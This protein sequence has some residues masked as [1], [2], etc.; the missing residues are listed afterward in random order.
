MHHRN[1][2]DDKTSIG[3]Y[4][5]IE[6]A[7]I[8]QARHML[9]WL[10]M[11]VVA[12]LA[13]AHVKPNTVSFSQIPIGFAAAALITN[14]PRVAF[15]LFLSALLLDAVD[16]ALARKQC[17]MSS[18][19]SL[20]D[21]ISDH[22]REITIIGGLVV[23]DAMHGGIGVAYA[24]LYPAAN[25]MLYISNRLNTSV[26]LAIKTWLSF[27]PFLFVFLWFDINYLDYAAAVAAGFMVLTSAWALL[28]VRRR[29]YQSG[30]PMC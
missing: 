16:G 19:G 25:I 24:L 21:Q 2:R 15:G 13:R 9:A 5:R 23:A 4:S 20:A 18:Y 14:A 27:Y 7:L 28:L 11:P 22:V 12:L 6:L 26:P 29:T 3:S 17:S 10:L 30:S 1:Q 8:N